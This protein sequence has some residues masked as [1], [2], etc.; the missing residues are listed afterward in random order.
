MAS[1]EVTRGA[2]RGVVGFE[3]LLDGVTDTEVGPVHVAGDHEDATDGQMVV[4][5]VGEPQSFTLGMET[6]EEG[7][8]RGACSFGATEHL[9][10]GIRILG[11]NTPV[12]GEEGCKTSGVWQHVEEVVPTDVLSA[13]FGDR[14]MNQVTGPGDGTE[15]E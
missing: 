7:Q 6:A 9:I 10:Q 8:D 15:A 11:I 1:A 13:C 14:H 3:D 5:D 12:A 4:G 2:L